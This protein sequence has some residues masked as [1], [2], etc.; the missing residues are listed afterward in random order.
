[1]P[2]HPHVHQHDVGP[3]QLGLADRGLAVDR[4]AHDLEVRRAC[5]A[6]RPGRA[7]PRGGRRRAARG[8]VTRPSWRLAAPVRP[9][10]IPA[11]SGLAGN[12]PGSDAL[13][14]GVVAVARWSRPSHD[15]P[16]GTMS[17]TTDVARPGLH[18]TSRRSASCSRALQ[19]WPTS[20]GPLPTPG[21]GGRPA[22]GD[23]RRS[24]ASSAWSAWWPRHGLARQPA[25]PLRVAAGAII[26]VT[27]TGAAG[28]L[29]RRADGVKILVG[30]V[31][32]LTVATVVLMFSGDR[33]PRA[34]H[35][36]RRP[37]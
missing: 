6:A 24:A 28:V 32:V 13:A 7:G 8:S 18:H 10:T 33:R 19:R 17:T 35:G 29:R 14:A 36:L 27:L 1:M 5:R 16:G 37:P 21:R 23:P 11:W 9:G 34:G 2:G 15:S 20:R 4:L 12:G 25:L 22:A 3:G 26:V 31:V 30:F